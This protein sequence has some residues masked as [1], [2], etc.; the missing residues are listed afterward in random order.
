MK[1]TGSCVIS[2]GIHFHRVVNPF[3][4]MPVQEDI[5]FSLVHIGPQELKLDCDVLM[6]N[7]WLALPP[8]EVRL[9]KVKGMKVIVDVDDMW[10]I[11]PSHPN[12]Q[13]FKI[14]KTA[15]VTI[16]HIRL[17]DVVTCTTERLRDKI[18]QYNTNV[19][20]IP[21][22]LPFDRDQ[23]Q[24]GN[25]TGGKELSGHDKMRFMYLGGNTHADD[26]G[27]LEGKFKRIGGD[28]YINNRAEFIL[29]GY[30]ATYQDRKI[31]SNKEDY[32][33]KNG[34]Y[35][36]ETKLV[37]TDSDYMAQVFRSTNSFKVYPSVGLEEYLNYYDSA[38]VALAPLQDTMWNTMKSSLK[39]IEAAVKHIPIMCSKVAPYT[40]M[41]IPDNCGILWVTKPQDWL[42]LIR[43]CIKN[44][45]YVQEQGEKLY[46]Y[47]S[48]DYD[49]VKVNELRLQ[50][51]RSL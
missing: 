4:Y 24:V 5:K 10:D 15:E 7:K 23:Y 37:K 43:Y 51:L 26:I 40:D 47:I 46:E 12:Y 18:L 22:A 21:N 17:A 28:S 25:R 6:Y 41:G 38:E 50:V 20:I 34:N 31:Y 39:I 16:E 33:A 13:A 1:V 3:A 29:C 27:I 36:K 19:V 2:S 32:K 9:L 44:P 49:L 42:E 14:N 45:G 35:R 8:D 48:K 30:N 11:P